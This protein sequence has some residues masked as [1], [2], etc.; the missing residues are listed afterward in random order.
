MAWGPEGL[1]VLCMRP[2]WAYRPHA[3]PGEP[4]W[5]RLRAGNV[6]RFRFRGKLGGAGIVDHC[7]E[8]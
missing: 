4:L 3:A 2:G 5:I 8:T 7:R 1:A 6:R